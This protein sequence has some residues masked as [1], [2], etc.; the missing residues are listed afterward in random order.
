VTNIREIR[1]HAHPAE[2]NRPIK[3]VIARR[4]SA[5][6]PLAL[7]I[8]ARVIRPDLLRMAIDATV[9]DINATAAFRHSR[10]RRRID[11]GRLLVRL[12][13]E[14]PDLEIRNHRQAYPREGERAEDSENERP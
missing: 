13:I 6:A 4:A 9:R 14:V 12:R 2:Q 3:N 7:Q 5:L 11:I 1:A 10:T 8:G